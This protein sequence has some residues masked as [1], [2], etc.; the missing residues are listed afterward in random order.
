MWYLKNV[1][2]LLGH[3]VH[4]HNKFNVN[5]S[6]GRLPD[7]ATVQQRGRLVNTSYAA[8]RKLHETTAVLYRLMFA[9]E[10]QMQVW[11]AKV[12]NPG[13]AGNYS[14]WQYTS[15]FRFSCCA[16]KDTFFLKQSA[17]CPFKVIHGHFILAGIKSTYVTSYWSS[18]VTLVMSCPV[19]DILVHFT[20]KATFSTPT[21]PGQNFGVFPL[22]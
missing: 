20:P 11:V 6:C 8:A 3:P 1:R 18:V 9:N 14:C 16:P 21:I 19:S 5:V 22:G 13:I 10:S 7:K 4:S 15:T 12:Q 2:F 17:I